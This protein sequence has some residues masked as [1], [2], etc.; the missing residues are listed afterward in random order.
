MLRCSAYGDL[1]D[2]RG[3]WA[4]PGP[5]RPEHLG[6]A[7]RAGRAARPRHCWTGSASLLAARVGATSRGA[8]RTRSRRC[9]VRGGL[10]LEEWTGLLPHLERAWH[11]RRRRPGAQGGAGAAVG[12]PC[13]PSSRP[14]PGRRVATSRRHRPAPPCGPAAGRTG[15]TC[16]PSRSPAPVT[17][18][19]R[20]PRGA[21]AGPAALRGDVRPAR[22]PHVQRDDHARVLPLRRCPRPRAAR[23][24]GRA[25][26]RQQRPRRCASRPSATPARSRRGWSRCLGSDDEVELQHVL[27]FFSHGEP[28]AAAAHARPS[29]RRGRDH[30]APRPLLPGPHRRPA[31]AGAGGGPDPARVDAGWRPVVAG[32]GTAHRP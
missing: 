23:A 8:R 19:C 9:C 25:A 5:R 10:G 30:R 32:D 11:R 6:R 14:A 24:A 22:R 26:R 7:R 21:P 29:A 12:R 18:G 28:T 16:W 1:V 20:A 31:T 15:T 3:A 4:G 27:T 2:D 13:P 17:V